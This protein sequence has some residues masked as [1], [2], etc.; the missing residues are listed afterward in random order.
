MTTKHL[1]LKTELVALR[2]PDP[3]DIA[4]QGAEVV[5]GVINLDPDDPPLDQNPWWI[6]LKR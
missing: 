3:K 5:P 4:Q 1:P 2:F 6:L